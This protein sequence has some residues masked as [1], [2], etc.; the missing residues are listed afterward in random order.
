MPGKV[1]E[2]WNVVAAGAMQVAKYSVDGGA[3]V[4]V[5]VFPSD[6]GGLAAN[7]L[8]WRRQMGLPE[9]GAEEAAGAAKPIEGGPEGA[10]VVDLEN[11]EKAL[12]GAIVPRGGRW[13]FYK[14]TGPTAAVKAARE[15]FVNFAK[16]TP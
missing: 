11:G 14:L 13:F 1:P 9:V 5:S 12:G 3:E 7:V 10:V 4:A 16:A 2:G 15:T 8:R 6:T